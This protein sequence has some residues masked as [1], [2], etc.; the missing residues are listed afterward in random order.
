[1]YQIHKNLVNEA[2]WSS[3]IH[4]ARWAPSALRRWTALG[5]ISAN[6]KEVGNICY[7][8]PI[9][10]CSSESS[11]ISDALKVQIRDTILYERKWGIWPQYLEQITAT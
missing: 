2:K 8:H 10:L 11:A 4:R 3:R 7:V 1:L 9:G 6:E 5:I